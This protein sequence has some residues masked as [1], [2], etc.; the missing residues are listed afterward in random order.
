MLES[1]GTADDGPVANEAAMRDERLAAL[2][3]RVAALPAGQQEGLLMRAVQ[4]MSVAEVATA[5]GV[6]EGTVK[7]RMSAAVRAVG[8]DSRDD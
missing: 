5:L 1:G 3:Q 4:G 2:H 6:P 8:Q 7:S